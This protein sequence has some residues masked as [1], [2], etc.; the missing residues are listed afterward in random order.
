MKH[1]IFVCFL[2]I[3]GWSSQVSLGQA[4]VVVQEAKIEGVTRIRDVIYGYKSG[5]ALTMDVLKPTRPNGIG[6]VY[7]LSGGWRSDHSMI[8]KRL[9]HFKYFTNRGQTVFLIIHGSAPKFWVNEVIQDVHRAV[10]FI[11]YHANEYNVDPN[12]LGV[13]GMSSGG[14][15]SLSIGTGLGKPSF[16]TTSNDPVDQVSSEVQAVACFFPPTDL[17]NFGSPERLFVEQEHLKRYRS[18][19]AIDTK[20]REEQ[21]KVMQELSPIYAVSKQMSPILILHGTQDTIV[22]LEQSER[23]IAR[24][25]E[26]G[27]PAQ[28][29]IH[30]GGEHGWAETWESDLNHLVDWF[31]KYLLGTK[32]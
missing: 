19:F 1:W 21:R 25:K 17:V 11:R 26:V 31:E 27:V 4:P 7:L 22:P 24:V 14:H 9:R 32:K 12:R 28:L 15:L 6:V 29:I 10:R 2:F 3:T 23:F 13:S 5:M 16:S 30:Q 20:P 8:E 18:A